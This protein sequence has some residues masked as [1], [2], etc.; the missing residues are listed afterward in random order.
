MKK[1]LIN[2]R[3]R[4][5]V[6]ALLPALLLLP[7]ACSIHR[8][9]IQQGNIITD[10]MIAKLQPGMTRR[11][12]VFVLG[13]PTIRDPF[14]RDRWDYVYSLDAGEDGSVIRRRHLVLYFNK[15]DTLQRHTLSGASDTANSDATNSDATTGGDAAAGASDRGEQ[16]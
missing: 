9:E 4:L 5:P 11:Q 15:D 2:F 16:E 6:F 8:P 1:I 7:S 10:D 3:S 13:T 12:V 14:H